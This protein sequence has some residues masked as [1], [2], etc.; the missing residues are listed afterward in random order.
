MSCVSDV[1]SE[2][3]PMLLFFAVQPAL[4]VAIIMDFEKSITFP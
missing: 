2:L 4:V 1:L 3:N